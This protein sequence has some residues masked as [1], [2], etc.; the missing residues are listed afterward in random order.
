VKPDE[1]LT[2]I[3]RS[4]QQ[5]AFTTSNSKEM[6]E[7]LTNK[8]SSMRSDIDAMR[9]KV[10]KLKQKS[11]KADFKESDSNRDQPRTQL[12]W[13]PD[14]YHANADAA[15]KSTG[16]TARH[17]KFQQSVSP[18][19]II[20]AVTPGAGP[21]ESPQKETG[22]RLSH[23][24]LGS[25]D[26]L[27]TSTPVLSPMMSPMM[28]APD[29]HPGLMHTGFV[30]ATP[31][32][33]LGSVPSSKKHDAPDIQGP[34][35][36]VDVLD[37]RGL[38]ARVDAMQAR[39]VYTIQQAKLARGKTRSAATGRRGQVRGRETKSDFGP[40]GP[41]TSGPRPHQCG[42]RTLT[43]IGNFNVFCLPVIPLS[44]RAPPYIVQDQEGGNPSDSDASSASP[45]DVKVESSL[46][47]AS[48]PET[49]SD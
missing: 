25:K 12:T 10:A 32:S 16:Q 45:E 28:L 15:V 36:K 13:T 2:A 18:V 19:P 34:G 4:L 7:T 1:K 23:G 40:A 47:S 33:L 6:V 24:T 22:I 5:T 20:L 29:T 41:F 39:L 26:S 27:G 8:V 11:R 35:G 38:N 43:T 49:A 21:Q 3:L 46:A 14:T 9:R 30:I 37:I 17:S 31:K 48:K 42:C 44:T